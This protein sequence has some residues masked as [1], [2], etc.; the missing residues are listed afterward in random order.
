LAKKLEN[1]FDKKSKFFFEE[2]GPEDFELGLQ[3]SL[4]I[5]VELP[6]AEIQKF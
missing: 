4:S 1:K 3:Q 2:S 5:S 6:K